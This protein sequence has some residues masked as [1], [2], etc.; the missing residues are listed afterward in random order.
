M[1]CYRGTGKSLRSAQRLLKH[2]YPGP[3]PDAYSFATVARHDSEKMAVE[4]EFDF[5]AAVVIGNR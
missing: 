4:V 1:N 2:P 3:S 5:E